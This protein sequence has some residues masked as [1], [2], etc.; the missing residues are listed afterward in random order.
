MRSIKVICVV[1]VAVSAANL[2][3]WMMGSALWPN[4]VNGNQF[5]YKGHNMGSINIAKSFE[6][7]FYF[8]P[9]PSASGLDPSIKLE[10][11]LIQIDKIAVSRGVD[12]SRLINLIN[13]LAVKPS[14]PIW[15]EVRVNIHELNLA[16]DDLMAKD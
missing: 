2:L 3:I 8:T 6:S 11:A 5:S 16:L 10:E 1:I 9:Y 12:K 15:G 14:S 13:Q 7:D 4:A